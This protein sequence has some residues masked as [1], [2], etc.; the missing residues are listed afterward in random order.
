MIVIPEDAEA[1]LSAFRPDPGEATL[2]VVTG[3]ASVTTA[4]WML[5]GGD[6]SK[7]GPAADFK[8]S[9]TMPQLRLLIGMSAT[10]SVTREDHI[11]FQQM[12][13]VSNGR[14]QIRYIRSDH[15]RDIHSK[16][17]V[18]SDS[19]LRATRAWAGSAN[20]TMQGL[21]ISTRSQENHLDA[22]P[23]DDA[24]AY[25]LSRWES[26]I[27]CIAN[28]VREQVPLES[29]RFGTESTFDKVSE[30]TEFGIEES[31]DFYL[32]SHSRKQSYG[33][34]AGV[35]WGIRPNRV[36]RDEAYLAIPIR[37]GESG[38]FPAKNTP[39]D[40]VCDD[41]EI[42]V[43]R[44]AS[45]SARS[46]KDLTTWPTNASLGRYLR[47]RLGVPPGELIRIEDLLRYGRTY[48]TIS[49]LKNGEYILDFS[50]ETSK[51]DPVANL[52]AEE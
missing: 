31:E 50:P 14:V 25:V 48:V 12:E 52:V 32:Y 36:S 2:H 20:F 4:M 46:G 38:F 44:G 34:G 9:S 13:R 1:V 19:A 28:D 7:I 26:A 41:G 30:S 29:S 33:G 10:G 45:G 40:V 24:L 21:G 37:V 23:A 43:L 17:Y 22:I 11:A 51:P 15:G 42:L 6:V 47:S 16:L 35:N 39:F 27:S 3:Y 49:R 18:W 5:Y 8:L